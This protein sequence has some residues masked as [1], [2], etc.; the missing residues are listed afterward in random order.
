MVRIKGASPVRL[1]QEQVD[2]AYRWADEFLR[3]HVKQP[4]QKLRGD[5]M[6]RH[7]DPA[8]TYWLWQ[9][10]ASVLIMIALYMAVL[11]MWP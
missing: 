6:L 2:E 8:P 10:V 11:A 5:G 4:H 7:P 9:I 1:T 3:D